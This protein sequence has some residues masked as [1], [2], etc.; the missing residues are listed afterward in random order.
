LERIT[1]LS[2]QVATELCKAG[3]KS[4]QM[5]VLTHTPVSGQAILHFHSK[6]PLLLPEF[7]PSVVCPVDEVNVLSTCAG[8]CTE[9]RS[10]LVDISV[11]DYFEEPDTQEAK[12]LFGEILT[13]LKG[14][15][16][17]FTDTF[18]ESC[19]K[20]R[21]SERV[22]NQSFDSFLFV[23]SS[24]RPKRLRLGVAAMSSLAEDGENI[25]L[26][27]YLLSWDQLLR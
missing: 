1:D 17:L 20:I 8:V 4:L 27:P 6:M 15:S 19:K 23:L 24:G 3:L 9:I 25:L 26:E 18:M 22:G 7:R 16:F 13:T 14:S 5:L 12:H 21:D 10:I 11:S 2:L